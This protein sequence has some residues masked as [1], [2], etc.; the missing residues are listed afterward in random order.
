MVDETNINIETV[1]FTGSTNSD[2][3]KRAADGAPEG[4]WLRAKSQGAGRGRNSR[5]WVSPTGNIYASTII[6][7]NADDPPATNLAFVAAV[8]LFDSLQAFIPNKALKIKWPN[9]LLVEGAK[10]CGILL[11][12]SDDAVI[13]GCGVNLAHSPQNIDRMATSIAELV[14]TAPSADEFMPILAKNFARWLSIWRS[15]G[16]GKIR[17]YWLENAHPLGQKIAYGDDIGAF[18]GLSNSGAC[19]LKLANGETI[20]INA[21][22]IFLIE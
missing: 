21:G 3:L 17:D 4:L 11:E 6:R 12:R 18:A 20:S 7:L 5:D 13:M 16:F 8:A 2:L 10:I 22:D 14:G 19:L 9:D 1:D 15:E